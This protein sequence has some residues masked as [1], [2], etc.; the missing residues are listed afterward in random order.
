MRVISFAAPSMYIAKYGISRFVD[1]TSSSDSSPSPFS[2]AVFPVVF[3]SG[4]SPPL[5]ASCSS[6]GSPSLPLGSSSIIAV[7]SWLAAP[8]PSC[9]SA[10]S[11]CTSCSS[12]VF[13]DIVSS[14]SCSS[15]ISSGTGGAVPLN[16]LGCGTSRG[17]CSPLSGVGVVVV[18]S[19]AWPPGAFRF[20]PPRTGAAS[21]LS[22][23]SASAAS[24]VGTFVCPLLLL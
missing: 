21:L 4:P 19:S 11:F 15:G 12:S 7:C 10:V 2:V 8:R 6:S 5:V 23:S 17:R 9:S 22:V 24:G 18:S 14:A 20:T 13:S 16:S 3:A 1:C